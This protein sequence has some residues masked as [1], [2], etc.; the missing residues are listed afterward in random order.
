MELLSEG[1][2]SKLEHFYKQVISILIPL[3]V[4]LLLDPTL[5]GAMLIGFFGAFVTRFLLEV[6][7]PL[8]KDVLK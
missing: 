2:M 7:E 5:L 3:I 4:V 6:L 8:L 1:A